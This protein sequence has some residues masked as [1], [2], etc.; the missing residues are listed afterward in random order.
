MQKLSVKAGSF[1][2]RDMRM[3]II[4]FVF[5]IEVVYLC[6]FM[7]NLGNNLF[8]SIAIF[9]VVAI[10]FFI[11]K[12]KKNFSI[13]PSSGATPFLNLY[14]TDFTALAL[15]G[16]IDPVVGREDEVRKLT[17]VLA[18]RSKN[19]AILIGDPGVGKTAI[20]EGLAQRIAHKE[21]PE[22]LAGKRV[23]ALDVTTLMS[24]TKYR[25][26]FEERAKK[27]VQEITNSNRTIIL[28]ID[29][30]HSVV[31]SQGSEGSVNL[32]D[33]LKPA[34]ARGDLQMVGATTTT[35][36]DK[37]FRVDLSLERRFQ[38]IE[39]S[40]AT[41]KEAI[42][43][44]QGIKDKYREYHKVEF[45]DA[46][47]ETAVRLTETLV[48]D[49]KL[50]D[51]AIDAIDEAAAMVKVGHLHPVL[52]ATLYQVALVTYPEV[53]DLWKQIQELDLKI[54]T[55]AGLTDLI[56]K[57]ETLENELANKGVIAVDTTD[58]EKIIKDWIK[59]KLSTGRRK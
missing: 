35:E 54:Q 27:I 31:Q 51:K 48:K 4:H 24:G 9:I 11:K 2:I 3:C 6:I 15:A 14:T 43:I 28:F 33:I 20:V 19:N 53:A 10:Y 49:R 46:A 45:T 12:S 57:R 44:L 38:P 8:I 32:S 18:R 29:E 52:T 55:R 58:I 5:L 42:K 34:L 39:V 22:T 59:P 7:F 23:L 41:P 26:E 36:Y 1:C 30:V 16:R 37:Y 17:Q 25:G 50:P 21:V 40:E 47:L 56:S 13:R